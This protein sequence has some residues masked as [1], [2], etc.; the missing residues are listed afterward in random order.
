MQHH[1][2]NYFW[3][4]RSADAEAVQEFHAWRLEDDEKYWGP[5]ER[6]NRWHAQSVVVASE[7][8][9]KGVGRLLMG[10]VLERARDDGVIVG[11]EASPEGERLYRALGFQMLGPFCKT[12]QG[13]SGGGVMLW[14]PKF[15]TS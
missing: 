1:S 7:W 14:E 9:R 6:V 2:V 12:L 8:Q 11:V 15:T 3:P 10:V 4:D 13:T 5:R